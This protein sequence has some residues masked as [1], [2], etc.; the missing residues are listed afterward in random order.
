MRKEKKYLLTSLS[1][2]VKRTFYS[3]VGSASI[4]LA[5]LYPPNLQV[6]S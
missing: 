2:F 6:S 3:G 4:H 1:S 5:N